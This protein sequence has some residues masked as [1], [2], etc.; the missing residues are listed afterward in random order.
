MT[1][2]DETEGPDEHEQATSALWEAQAVIQLLENE[3]E[4]EQGNNWSADQCERI[5]WSLRAARRRLDEAVPAIVQ[6][7]HRSYGS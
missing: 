6:L 5:R 4:T 1:A 3:L 7:A 2:N